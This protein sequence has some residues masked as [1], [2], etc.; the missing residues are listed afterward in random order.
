M[1][2]KWSVSFWTERGASQIN[3]FDNQKAMVDYVEAHLNR[4]MKIWCNDKCV[5][6]SWKDGIHWTYYFDREGKQER[7]SNRKIELEFNGVD[8]DCEV[9]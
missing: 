6:C 3:Y 7:I 8:G 4:T 5:G 2:K 9:S 1:N